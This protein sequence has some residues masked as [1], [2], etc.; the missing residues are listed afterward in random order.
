MNLFA[1]KRSERLIASQTDRR[2]HCVVSAW[3][4]MAQAIGISMAIG[5]LLVASA[6]AQIVFHVDSTLDLLD[7]NTFDSTCDTGVGTCTLRAATM[8]ANR[9]NADVTIVLPAGTYTLT[10]SPTNDDGGGAIKLITPAIGNPLITIE[11]AGAASTIIDAHGIDR[12]FSVESGR[13][14]KLSGIALIHGN[15][16]LPGGAGLLNLGDL[17]L[18]DSTI[19][20]NSTL[21]GGGGIH[22]ESTLAASHITLNGNQALS[23]STTGRGGGIYNHGSLVMTRSTLSAND[24]Y[25]EGGGLYSDESSTATLDLMTFSGNHA[26][27]GGGGGIFNDGA[28]TL[29]QST[30]SGNAGNHGGG[31]GGSVEGMLTL[32]RTTVSGN[33]GNTGGGIY[34][35]GSLFVS[36]STIGDNHATR[37]GGG[38]YNHGAS[39][40]DNTTL[41]YNE[42]DSDADSVGSGAGIYNDGG[43]STVR[44]S[45]IAGNLVQVDHAYEDC[46]GLLNAYG[47]NKFSNSTNAGVINCIPTQVGPGD[48]SPLDSFAELGALR[49]NGGPTPTYALVP[50]SDMIDGAEA[51]IGCIDYLGDPLATDQRGYP[52]VA[53]ARCD[54]GAFEYSDVIFRNGFD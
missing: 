54:I 10:Q 48:F 2:G 29:D 32:T 28:M 4:R 23:T 12:V 11:G 27:V 8:Q 13:R 47:R 50:P 41:V 51:T 14:A 34:N 31:I 38:L 42:A 25:V 18:G 9:L 5:L 49:A 21:G 44:N 24:A 46:Y 36:N 3:F 35:Y 39:T 40:V 15:G 26:T 17:T 53:G 22:N 6:H 37:D 43:Q 33:T 20:D 16:P 45:I 30:L 52:R 1:R 19:A 7:A